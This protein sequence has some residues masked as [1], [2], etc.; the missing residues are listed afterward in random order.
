RKREHSL[1][2]RLL[3]AHQAVAARSLA[4]LAQ[5]PLGRMER[6]RRALSDIGD[7]PAPQPST[8]IGREPAQIHALEQDLTGSDR[9]P[10]PCISESGEPDGR[11]ARA[12]LADQA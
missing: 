2:A 8:L 1:G 11:F 9:T 12:R 4:D 7:A 5:Q 6:G 10:R 3:E